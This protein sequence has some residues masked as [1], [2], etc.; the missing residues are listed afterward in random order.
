MSRS[1]VTPRVAKEFVHHKSDKSGYVKDDELPNPVNP[2]SGSG[3]I[4]GRVTPATRRY[5]AKYDIVDVGEAMRRLRARTAGEL[6]VIHNGL[7]YDNPTEASEEIGEYA[8]ATNDIDDIDDTTEY[9]SDGIYLD[10]VGGIQGRDIDNVD[11]LDAM[12]VSFNPDYDNG[13]VS[14][15]QVHST[16]P[17]QPARPPKAQ[18]TQP[19]RPTRPTQPAQRVARPK[20]QTIKVTIGLGDITFTVPA[21]K[22]LESEYGILLVLPD[23]DSA[24]GFTPKPGTELR[25]TTTRNAARAPGGEWDC[26]FPGGV[27]HD[28]QGTTPVV[29]LPLIRTN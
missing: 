29:L 23:D 10:K 21:Y 13:G 25:V 27:Y 22:L 28:T 1:N 19:T 5:T 12:A 18:P 24:M 7:D 4:A 15:Q 16:Q 26:Y 17:V 2:G 9:D 3:G 11:A 14:I 20:P 8:N 6:D